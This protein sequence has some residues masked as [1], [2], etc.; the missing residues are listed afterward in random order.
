MRFCF[1]LLISGALASA[2]IHDVHYQGLAPLHIMP[3]FDHGYLVV[4][5]RDQSVDVYASDGSLRYKASVHGPD[6]S[7]AWIQNAAVDADGTL[8]VTVKYP[9]SCHVA[10]LGLI[11]LHHGGIAIFDQSGVQTRV[12]DTRCDYWPHRLHSAQ[13]THSGR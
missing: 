3:T 10:G 2:Q 11:Q 13:S 8:A 9:P 7:E 6:G 5:D 12:I 4:Y 1:L